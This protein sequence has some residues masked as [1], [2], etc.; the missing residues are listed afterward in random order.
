MYVDNYTD[1][2]FYRYLIVYKTFLSLFVN[3]RPTYTVSQNSE[4]EQQTDWKTIGHN[5]IP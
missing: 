2:T 4:L 3:I 1:M 5:V